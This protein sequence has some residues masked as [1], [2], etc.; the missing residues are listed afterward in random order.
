[1]GKDLYLNEKLDKESIKKEE[2]NGM[3]SKK[4][5]DRC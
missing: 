2:I 4:L 3:V 5:L 1:M